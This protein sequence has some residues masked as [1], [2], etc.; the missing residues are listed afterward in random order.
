MHWQT[1]QNYTTVYC[2]FDELQINVGGMAIH[3]ED[4]W[5]SFQDAGCSRQKQP[6]NHSRMCGRSIQPDSD[7][8]KYVQD[9]PP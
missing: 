9:G 7:T 3:E 5:P 8:L 4:Y 2:K 1:E 6:L